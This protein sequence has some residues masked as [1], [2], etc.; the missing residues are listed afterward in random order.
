MK[1]ALNIKNYDD[2]LF[3]LRHAPVIG[4][5]IAEETLKKSKIKTSNMRIRMKSKPLSLSWGDVRIQRVMGLGGFSVVSLVRVSKIDNSYQRTNWYALKCLNRKSISGESEDFAKAAECLY[6]EASILMRLRHQNIVEIHGVLEDKGARTFQQPGGYFMVLQC[7]KRTVGDLL[8]TWRNDR[9]KCP[10]IDERISH[11]AVGVADGV[12][13]LHQNRIIYR[14]IKPQ[15]VGID[16][17]G[18][19]RLFDFGT[20]AE[21]PLDQNYM[22]G[23][24]G[25]FSYMA[26]EILVKRIAY[27]SSD[28]YS[29]AIF[30]WQLVT[31][32]KPYY[33][34]ITE[35]TTMTYKEYRCKIGNLGVRPGPMPNTTSDILVELIQD[36]WQSDHTRRPTFAVILQRV[37]YSLEDPHSSALSISSSEE[38][39]ASFHKN[40]RTFFSGNIFRKRHRVVQPF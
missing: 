13:Y 25:S 5:E 28:V 21:L 4:E 6:T 17:S 38:S 31:L 24:L 8:N 26:P 36:C 29:F 22:P 15:N 20:A 40:A 2:D 32:E 35:S 3:H 30:L 7:M 9:V 37:K 19:P 27:L 18:N 39:S 12:K 23:C 14:D 10:R 33:N 16:Y 11:I 1:C 34:E